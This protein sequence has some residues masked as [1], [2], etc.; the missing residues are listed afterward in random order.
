MLMFISNRNSCKYITEGVI[1]IF[2]AASI[3][4]PKHQQ[5]WNGE[6]RCGL[7]MQKNTIRQ[8]EHTAAMCHNI[9]ESHEHNTK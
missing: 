8:W 5:W 9:D 3:I 6:I 4:V 7:V 1:I 2:I